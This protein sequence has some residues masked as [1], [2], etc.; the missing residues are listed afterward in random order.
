MMICRAPDIRKLSSRFIKAK[1]LFVIL[2]VSI[3]LILCALMT[4]AMIISD[5]PETV[6][7]VF[8]G[9]MIF[10]IIVLCRLVRRKDTYFNSFVVNDKGS[11]IFIN[12][13]NI[14]MN[15]RLFGGQYNNA[16]SLKMFII[17][18][19]AAKRMKMFQNER[20][21]DAF[22]MSDPVLDLGHYVEKVFSVKS[23]RKYITARVR[24]KQC[25]S[26]Q[27]NILTEFTKT[28]RIAKNFK[29]AGAIELVLGSAIEKS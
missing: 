7:W 12:L 1:P 16:N 25:N 6:S 27:S 22:I 26:V 11:L 10:L 4:A 9:I 14:F 23:S 3:P 28:I 20:D 15:S 18:F 5:D 24:L 13:G 29:N 19:R 8:L 2:W 17:W 21:F